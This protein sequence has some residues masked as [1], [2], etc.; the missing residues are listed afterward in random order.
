MKAGSSASDQSRRR[1]QSDPSVMAP[2]KYVRG[3]S[4]LCSRIDITKV[5][6]C[7]VA[8]PPNPL[9]LLF[10]H[11]PTLER[12]SWGI[13]QFVLPLHT[14]FQQCDFLRERAGTVVQ[15]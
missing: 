4:S 9:D 13:A 2:V 6:A 12:T 8:V 3:S 15:F 10:G 11:V 5:S 7:V 1:N 14:I